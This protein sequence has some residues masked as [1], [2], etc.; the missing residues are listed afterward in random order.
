MIPPDERP[1]RLEGSLKLGERNFRLPVPTQHLMRLTHQLG[2]RVAEDVAGRLVHIG[3]PTSGVED[4]HPETGR[5]HH[6]EKRD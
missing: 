6:R 2:S 5:L 3:K 4:D 1:V